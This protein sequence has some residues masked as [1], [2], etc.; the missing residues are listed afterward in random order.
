MFDCAIQLVVDPVYCNDWPHVTIG[1]DQQVFFEGKLDKQYVLSIDKTF[2]TVD[3]SLWIELKYKTA[4]NT[5]SSKDQAVIIKSLS[6]ENIESD[7]FVWHANYIPQYPEPWASEQKAQSIILEP[8]IQNTRYLGWNGIWK[9]DFQL[10]IFTWIH[11]LEN[12]GWLY[13]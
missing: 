2:S 7:R 10:P 3:H 4:R 13:V 11:R 5:T 1:L 9:L 12:L 8:V 6:F